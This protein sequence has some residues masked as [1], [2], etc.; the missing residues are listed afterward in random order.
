MVGL[1]E[2]DT[3]PS[4]LTL[5]GI[6]GGVTSVAFAPDGG[7][8]A[9]CSEDNSVRVCEVQTGT[10]LRTLANLGWE[11][12]HSVFAGRETITQRRDYGLKHG[13]IQTHQSVDKH[14]IIAVV[15]EKSPE[16]LLS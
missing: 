15:T 4:V 5:I 13:R 11:S 12:L 16:T 3:G 6:K 9:A 14:H 2:I 1:W 7:S 8:L 10:I